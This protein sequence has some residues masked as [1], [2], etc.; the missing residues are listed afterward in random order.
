MEKTIGGK[1]EMSLTPLVDP[2]GCNQGAQHE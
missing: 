2:F 1:M